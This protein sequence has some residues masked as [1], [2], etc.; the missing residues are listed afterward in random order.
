MRRGLVLFTFC[1]IIAFQ[2]SKSTD[3]EPS[4]AKI[5]GKVSDES[6]DVF[7]SGALVTTFPATNSVSTSSD[8]SYSIDDVE[9]GEY[10]VT[11]TKSGFPSGN[12][13]VS[14]QEGK[15]ANADIRL[16]IMLGNSPPKKPQLVSPQNKSEYQEIS[17]ILTWLESTDSDGDN[18]TYDLYFDTQSPPVLYAGNLT[19]ELYALENLDTS[20]TYY[21][22]VIAKDTKGLSSASDIWEFKTTPNPIPK[23]GLIAYWPFN[24]N[25]NDESGNGHNGA[26]NGATLVKDRFGNE[27]RAFQ[28][29]SSDDYINIGNKIR[30]SFPFTV[31]GWLFKEN[32]SVIR[33]IISDQWDPNVRYSGFIINFVHD[34]NKVIC[35]FGNGYPSSLTRKIKTT[36]IPNLTLAWHNL[37]I[38]YENSN[39]MKVFVDGV[40]Y[41]GTYDGSG[42]S[43]G[44]TNHN[45][46]IGSNGHGKLD[47]LR[48]YDR[49]L[50]VEEINFLYHEAGWGK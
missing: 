37:T 13:N 40:E 16:G 24:G 28:F 21:W 15:T 17:I 42:N 10:L 5:S 12:V 48:V 47:D 22:Q 4:E 50:T 44:S 36:V 39:V 27:D 19:E 29:G 31:S 34:E 2:C 49:A 32:E 18:V 33:L 7:V 1:L 14:V 20:E 30:P 8:G 41:S 25:A 3:P 45:G 38:V 11:A 9:P 43:M 26:V 46:Y 6:G 23:D 35:A